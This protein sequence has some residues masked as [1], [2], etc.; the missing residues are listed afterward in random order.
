[1]SDSLVAFIAALLIGCFIVMVAWIVGTIFADLCEIL[2]RA[3]CR[4]Y[5]NRKEPSHGE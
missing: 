5:Y 3:I 1:M 4:W 2:I